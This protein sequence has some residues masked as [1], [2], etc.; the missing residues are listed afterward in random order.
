MISILEEV[1][2]TLQRLTCNLDMRNDVNIEEYF[3]IK[4]L[5]VLKKF[6]DKSDGLYQRRRDEF[7]D[8][9]YNTVTNTLRLK[10]PFESSLLATLFT[11]DFMSSHKWPGTRYIKDLLMKINKYIYIYVYFMCKLSAM[12]QMILTLLFLRNLQLS[13]KLH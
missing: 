10:R 8:Q 1:Q 5:A 11:C 6:L 3:P 2:K 4:N 13:S 12:I 9:L 7:E